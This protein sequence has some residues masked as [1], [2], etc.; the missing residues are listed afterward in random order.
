[1]IVAGEGGGRPSL[2]KFII[3]PRSHGCAQISITGHG[4][5]SYQWFLFQ[6]YTNLDP[7]INIYC[8]NMFSAKMS[9]KTLSGYSPRN[10]YGPV[11]GPAGLIR[12]IVD[13]SKL[14]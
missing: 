11:P 1:M 8:P 4:S 7:A 9:T 13:S 12:L 3:N 2:A 14:N 6:G 10:L 5:T